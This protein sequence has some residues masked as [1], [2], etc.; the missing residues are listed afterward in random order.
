MPLYRMMTMPHEPM[1][2]V[3]CRGMAVG[4]MGAAPRN[5]PDQGRG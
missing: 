2:V 5:L 1:A 3:W 4:L